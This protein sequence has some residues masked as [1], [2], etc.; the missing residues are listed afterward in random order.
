MVRKAEG[1]VFR[2]REGMGKKKE[3]GRVTVETEER[4]V[5][6]RMRKSDDI[7]T[8]RSPPEAYRPLFTATC[9]TNAPSQT[10]LS[11]A[12]EIRPRFGKA[13][14]GFIFLPFVLA[15]ASR[16]RAYTWICVHVC[17][18]SASLLSRIKEKRDRDSALLSALCSTRFFLEK[19]KDA[20]CLKP[21]TLFEHVL[22]STSI[23]LLRRGTSNDTLK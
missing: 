17:V 23:S 5:D 1:K 4:Q 12:S 18:C 7:R 20:S 2:R 22:S 16:V 13:A 14:S 21:G 19:G 8:S 3:V 11:T 6:G 15:S 9:H 10:T